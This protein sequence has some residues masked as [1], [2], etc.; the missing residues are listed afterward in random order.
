M[1]WPAIALTV[2]NYLVLA[3]YDYL[4]IRYTGHTQIPVT[5]ILVASLISYPISN[6]TGQAW[7]S[8]GSVRYRFYSAWGIPGWDIVKISLFLTL[9][10]F[11]G[12]LT[13][14]LGS[15][16]LLPRFLTHPLKN[17]HTISGLTTLCALC[18]GAYWL[19]VLFRKKPLAFK[20]LELRIPSIGMTLGQT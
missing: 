15:S 2:V 10:Y 20:G 4:A 14:G 19:A 13:L 3:G 1:S 12:I 8:G 7:A 9:T 18:L 5:K 17:P 16:L 11:L 6:N